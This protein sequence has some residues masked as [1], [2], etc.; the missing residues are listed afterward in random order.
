MKLLALDT[1]SGACSVALYDDGRITEQFVQAERD[2]TRRLLPMVDEVLKQAGL[3]LSEVDALA[4]SR[5][6]GSFTGLRIA[7]SCVQGLAF[8][9][10]KPVVPVSSL[11]ALAAGA[12]R[13]HSEWQQAPVIAAL[14]A[15]MGQIYW[16]VYS[17]KAP[18]CSLLPEA[19]QDPE[20]AVYALRESDLP[21][22]RYGAGPGWH[23]PA[24]EQAPVKAVD[25]EA[26][27]HARDIAE[28]AALLWE[29][30]VSVRA[31]ELE[32]LYL[33]DEITWQKRQKIRSQ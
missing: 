11:A 13:K 18:N 16:G 29:N 30:G 21:Q 3:E 31:E 1:T 32:P 14:D 22:E 10:D 23:Y 6:P 19:V 7:I 15:R 5:G 4:V 25:S 33:R 26:L 8:A 28:L 17:P 9:A 27:I 20:Q 24:L 2:H 12:R